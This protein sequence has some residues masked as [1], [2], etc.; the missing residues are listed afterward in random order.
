MG[1]LRERTEEELKG[2]SR[3]AV[4]EALRE[5]WQVRDGV[6][7]C[8]PSRGLLKLIRMIAAGEA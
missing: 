2:A 6:G 8:G 3:E 7:G 5:E 1:G 4:E